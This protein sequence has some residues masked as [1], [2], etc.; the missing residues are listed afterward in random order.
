MSWLYQQVGISRQAHFK[1]Q[2]LLNQKIVACQALINEVRHIRLEHPR[3][4]IRKIYHLLKPPQVGRDYFEKIM[5]QA[6]LQLNKVK[7]YRRTTYS[8]RYEVYDNLVSGLTL[9]KPNQLWVSDITYYQVQQQFYYLTFITDVY[10]R[11][12]VGWA[13][14]TRLFAEANLEALKRAFRQS[15]QPTHGLIHHSDRGIQ[16]TSNAYTKLLRDQGCRIS[17][18]NKAWENAHAERINGII[19]N[20]Y[21]QSPPEN[22]IKKVTEKV[23]KAVKLY[24]HQRPHWNLP[25]HMNPGSFEKKALSEQV[26]YKVKINY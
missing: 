24:N 11:K 21:L 1:A 19:K 8:Q 20:E 5:R 13:A 25:E 3:M 22:N 10:T 7:N 16:Y 14:S 6:G 23:R 18:G 2:A 26:D 15:K 4:G 9:H 12:I 17:M